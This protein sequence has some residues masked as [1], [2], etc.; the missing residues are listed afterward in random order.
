MSRSTAGT[1][2]ALLV[3][4]SASGCSYALHPHR[5]LEGRAYQAD[6][7]AEV[8]A[9]MTDAQV[10]AALGAPF[11][12]SEDE[13]LVVW[14]YFERAQLRGCRRSVFGITLGDT[15]IVAREAKICLRG[16]IVERVQ[17]SNP[18]DASAR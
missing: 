8:H 3:G 13:G 2:V 16:G 10:E 11:Q 18:R 6:R 12:T 17:S 7:V 1:F 9:G 4:M 14:R 15:P 5:T